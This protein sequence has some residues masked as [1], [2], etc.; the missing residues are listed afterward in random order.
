M[1]TLPTAREKELSLQLAAKDRE[2]RTL[3]ENLEERG[4]LL[5]KTKVPTRATHAETCMPW[6]WSC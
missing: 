1:A 3:Q 4:R 6:T 5:Q 2:V